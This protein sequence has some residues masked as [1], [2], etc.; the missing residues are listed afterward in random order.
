VKDNAS[1]MPLDNEK[2][3]SYINLPESGEQY[4]EKK[5]NGFLLP[6]PSGI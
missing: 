4:I 2:I 3:F 1:F 6:K 5:C